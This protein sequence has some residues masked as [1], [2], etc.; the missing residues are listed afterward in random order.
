MGRDEYCNEFDILY[1]G[2]NSACLLL[3][4]HIFVQPNNRKLWQIRIWIA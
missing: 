2:N 4:L 3:Y 1:F